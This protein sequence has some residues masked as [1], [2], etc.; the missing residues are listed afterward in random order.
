VHLLDIEDTCIT[1]GDHKHMFG[2]GMVCEPNS[3]ELWRML[4]LR[5]TSRQC[6]KA[7][8]NTVMTI[9]SGVRKLTGCSQPGP[10]SKTSWTESKHSQIDMQDTSD[11][12]SE[13]MGG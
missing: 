5:C 2:P 4:P 12:A 1:A 11:E 3:L 13:E 8:A 9:H 6:L 10:T 7:E